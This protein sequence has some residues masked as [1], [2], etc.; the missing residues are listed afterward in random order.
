MAL[1]FVVYLLLILGAPSSA[2][3]ED[4]NCNLQAN[5]VNVKEEDASN[6][7]LA[8]DNVKAYLDYQN[9]VELR[10]HCADQ[11]TGETHQWQL[12]W[13]SV[14]FIGQSESAKRT[15]SYADNAPDLL[16]ACKLRLDETNPLRFTK[17]QRKMYNAA[18]VLCR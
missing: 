9:A 7:A 10:A 11:T 1:A 16:Y 12:L 18:R 15:E 8:D 13:E 6:E 4:H 14:D 2:K 17:E 5:L 3:T